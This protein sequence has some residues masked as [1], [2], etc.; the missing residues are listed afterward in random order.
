MIP[1]SIYTRGFQK[2]SA[3]FLML[4]I[5]NLKNKLHQFSTASRLAIQINHMTFSNTTNY[6]SPFST[7]I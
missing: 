6:Y 4:F 2:V 1:I 5:K 7:K 3:L